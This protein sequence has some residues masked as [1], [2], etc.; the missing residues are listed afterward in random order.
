MHFPYYFFGGQYIAKP[1][2]TRAKPPM[3]GKA[4]PLA[5]TTLLPSSSLLHYIN[6]CWH[7]TKAN[8]YKLK[9]IHI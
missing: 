3:A 6:H 2:P 1:K 5:A 4:P 9:G 8:V 7:L